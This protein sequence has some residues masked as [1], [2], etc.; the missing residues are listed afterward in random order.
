MAYYLVDATGGVADDAF[1]AAHLAEQDYQRSWRAN[2]AG[3]KIIVHCNSGTGTCA[4]L[5]ADTSKVV[6][7]NPAEF[8]GAVN[9]ADWDSDEL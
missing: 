4:T 2:L 6:Y 7:A 8:W 9:R 1:V 3:T 5:E